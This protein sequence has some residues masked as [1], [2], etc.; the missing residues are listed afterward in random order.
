MLT[1]HVSSLASIGVGA[2]VIISWLPADAAA[3][4]LACSIDA[5]SPF[6]LL[7]IDFS[8]KVVVDKLLASTTDLVVRDWLVIGAFFPFLFFL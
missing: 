3:L 7:L 2:L 8:S 1:N 5:C 6:L 4:V